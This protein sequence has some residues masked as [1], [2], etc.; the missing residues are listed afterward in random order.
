MSM[1]ADGGSTSAMDALL[2]GERVVQEPE[3]INWRRRFWRWVFGLEQPLIAVSAARAMMAQNEKQMAV[4]LDDISGG[5]RFT[6]IGAENGKIIRFTK[7]D[8]DVRV[9][10][11]GPNVRE[12][13]YVVKEDESL[14]DAVV[15]TLALDR[16]KT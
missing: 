6:I 15:K 16:L 11:R 12:A 8:D 14:M 2:G 3:R 4:K 13:Y 7:L 10:G 9:A 5:M 1:G